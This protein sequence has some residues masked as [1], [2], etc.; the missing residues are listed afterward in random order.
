MKILFSSYLSFLIKPGID[1]LT[2]I[3]QDLKFWEETLWGIFL[4]ELGKKSDIQVY[5]KI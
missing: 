3:N 4:G 5:S 1:S 2:N